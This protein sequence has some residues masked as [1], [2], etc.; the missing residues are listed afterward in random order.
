MFSI[1]IPTFN[2]FN[3]LKLCL[4]SI[5]KNSKFNHEI[6]VHINDGSDGTLEYIKSNNI[7]YTH[8]KKNIGL[9]SSLNLAAKKSSMKY[10]LYTH[11]DMYFCPSWDGY[12]FEDLT[13]LKHD[14][15]Y[16]SATMIEPFKGAHLTYDCG[17]SI[18][19]FNEN[20]LIEPVFGSNVLLIQQFPLLHRMNISLVTKM[21]TQI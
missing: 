19:T 12:L 5:K 9:C 20:K 17:K 15:F 21:I 4:D 11:D 10:L 1:L 6:I 18:G 14:F 8:S 13:N 3:Y 16:L 7:I 2:N